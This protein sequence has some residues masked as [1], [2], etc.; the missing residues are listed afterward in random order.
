MSITRMGLLC[1]Q[2]D[3]LSAATQL[4]YSQGGF[5]DNNQPLITDGKRLG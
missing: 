1:D 2:M 3:T 4:L 5:Y